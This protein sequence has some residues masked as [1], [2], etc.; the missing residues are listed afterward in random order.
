MAT[1]RPRPERKLAG[2]TGSTETRGLSDEIRAIALRCLAPVSD[3]GTRRFLDG[4]VR[5][6]LGETLSRRLEHERNEALTFAAGF[7]A[8]KMERVY[9]PALRVDRLLLGR[10]YLRALR[11]VIRDTLKEPVHGPYAALAGR[12]AAHVAGAEADPSETAGLRCMLDPFLWAA[13]V[14][15]IRGTDAVDLGDELERSCRPLCDDDGFLRAFLYSLGALIRERDLEARGR[16]ERGIVGYL[17]QLDE[18]LDPSIDPT[19]LA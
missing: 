18:R 7:F 17:E 9:D 1:D 2:L 10:E 8:E 4:L 16:A 12:F 13:E 14:A 15:R 5:R 6:L 19:G 3:P 11:Y